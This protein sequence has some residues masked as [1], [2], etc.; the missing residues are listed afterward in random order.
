[1]HPADGQVPYL[2]RGVRL[3]RCDLRDAW[4]LLA[5]ER[6]LKLDGPGFHILGTLDGERDFAAVAA[7]LAQ[8]FNAPAEKIANDARAFLAQLIERRMVE[9]R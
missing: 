2:P 8:D 3:R 7:K 6:A 9:I 5:P 1:M 4:Y